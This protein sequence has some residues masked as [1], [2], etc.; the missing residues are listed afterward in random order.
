MSLSSAALS[1]IQQAGAAVFAADA[2][3]KNA[4]KEYAERIN[5]A[6]VSNPYGLGND[7]M[8]E[9]WKVVA[10]LS[11]TVAGIEEELKKVFRVASELTADDRPTVTDVPALA[12]PTRS[13]E[14]D[15]NSQD[16]MTPTDVVVKTKK[17]TSPA[18][19]RAAKAKATAKVSRVKPAIASGSQP[20]PSG[21]PAKLLQH[22]ERILNPN[23]F[24]VIHQSAISLETGIPLGSMT[25]ATKKLIESG[26]II[27]GPSGSFKL[28][29]HAAAQA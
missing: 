29:N 5:A 2:E 13:V 24:T 4:V 10:R 6:M 1:A 12:A 21:N 15:M 14:S 23:E 18:K 16:D 3:L 22:L 28:A 27:A 11:Q 8:F 9:N 19:K 25:A 7:A 17:K 26:R 20:A